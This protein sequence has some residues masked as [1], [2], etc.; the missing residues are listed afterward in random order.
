MLLGLRSSGPHTNGY[1]LIRKVFEGVPLET[2][3]PE[4][5]VSLADALL[6]PHRSYLALI[7]SAIS[8]QRPGISEQGSVI[9]NQQ[10][11]ISNQQS[12][13]KALAHLTGGGFIENIPRVLPEG[14]NAVIRQGSWPVPR[15]FTLIQQRGGIASEEMY[16]VFNMGIGM[17]I[18]AAPEQAARLQAAIGE[19][20]WVIGEIIPG[21]GKVILL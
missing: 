14:V 3:F 7:Q 21:S 19:E 2:V 18:V 13:I 1:S 16:R 11:T 12:S 9:S 6:A 4:L 15:L 17:V 20:T 8:D 5:G 10:S